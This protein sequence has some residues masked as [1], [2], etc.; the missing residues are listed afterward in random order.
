[1]ERPNFTKDDSRALTITLVINIGLLIFSLLYTLDSSR[2]FRPSFIEVEFGEFQSGTLAEFSEVTNEEVA[3]RPNP[4][5]VEADEP[6][7]EAPQP[8][9]IVEQNN[10]EDT[11]PV[12]LPDEVEQVEAE[13]VNTPE[14]EKVDPTKQ[15]AEE[16]EKVEIPP[17]TKLDETVTEGAEESGDVTG[18]VGEINA[19]QGIGNDEDKTAPYQL[20]W[21]GDIERA[22]MVQPLPENTANMEG[23][24]TVRFQVRPDGNVGQIVPLRK[25]NPELERE[26][27]NTLRGWRF[28]RLPAGVPQQAQWGTITFRFVFN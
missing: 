18:A 2:N 22:P 10:E 21:E 3:T 27:M 5:E 11:K 14:T 12:D 7:E 24:I 16:Q 17:E 8:E 4:S 19:D 1:M 23:V 13:K 20:Q 28:S 6:Q 25:M 9:E 15:V 26:V